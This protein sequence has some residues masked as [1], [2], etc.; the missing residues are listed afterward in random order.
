MQ[1]PSY[2]PNQHRGFRPN[3]GYPGSIQPVGKFRTGFKRP[4]QDNFSVN[5]LLNT[6]IPGFNQTAQDAQQGIADAK[7]IVEFVGN[8]YIKI[9]VLLFALM[10]VANVVAIK[11]MK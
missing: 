2:I 11:I 9:A 7:K 10:V 6:F 8:N 3:V 4:Y 1:G 5:D